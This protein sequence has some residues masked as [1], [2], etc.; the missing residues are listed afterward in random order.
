MMSIQGSACL[1]KQEV[2]N[3]DRLARASSKEE[4]GEKEEDCL[5]EQSRCIVLHVA[6]VESILVESA[7]VESTG[8]L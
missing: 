6:I 5:I 1:S 4:E 3:R 2:T 7:A 8:R